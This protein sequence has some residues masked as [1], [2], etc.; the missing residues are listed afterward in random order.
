MDGRHG[1]EPIG[2]TGD[3]VWT[4]AIPQLMRQGGPSGQ[5]SQV[6]F[7]LQL[8]QRKKLKFMQKETKKPN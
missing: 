4:A 1:W 7:D 8:A 3:H 5:E 6:L 2:L